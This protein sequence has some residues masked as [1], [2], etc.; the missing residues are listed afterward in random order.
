MITKLFKLFLLLG[1]VILHFAS[2]H[3]DNIDPKAE[4]FI[5]DIGHQ[6][7]NI[8]TDQSLGFDQRKQ[9]FRSIANSKFAINAIGKFVLG[10]Y[11]RRA[12]EA[13]QQEFL[14][15]FKEIMLNTYTTRFQAYTSE[16]F[17]VLG[18]KT[19][20]DA[21]INVMTQISRPNG[22][23]ISIDW[24]LY[25]DKDSFLIY[26]VIIEDISM[27]ITQRTEYSSI[28]HKQGGRIQGLIDILRRKIANY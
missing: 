20:S 22:Q 23:I 17:E 3:A 8:L 14:S 9:K 19:E 27:S 28:I 4:N 24:K 13:E 18:S 1:I 26:D 6:A 11:W 12:T 10:K 15:L 21:S 2:A 5:T 16:R 7:I 25:Q